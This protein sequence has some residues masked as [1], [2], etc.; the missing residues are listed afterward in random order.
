MDAFF[1][2]IRFGNF[3]ASEHELYPVTFES[4]GTNTSSFGMGGESQE[5]YIGTNTIPN[6]YG[7]KYQNKLEF[8]ITFMP[9]PCRV[10]KVEFTNHEIRSILRE[11][12]GKQY[13]EDFY[14]L[15][16]NGYFDERLHFRVK[17][18][19]DPER[20]RI[21]GINGLKFYFTCD[22]FW[23]YTDPRTINLNLKSGQKFYIYNQSDELN[24]Y[25]YPIVKIKNCSGDLTITNLSDNSRKTVVKGLTSTEIVALDSRKDIISSTIDRNIDFNLIFPRLIPYKNELTVD[26]DCTLTI[27]FT[28]LRKVVF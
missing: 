18:V 2:D 7:T 20:I 10:N 8:S 4:S 19:D 6:D 23:A 25:L 27:T 1:K 22:S 9:N 21:N 17:L 28:E 3:V 26:K 16:D 15:D 13:Y 14:F 24:D 11:L 12:T 5:E